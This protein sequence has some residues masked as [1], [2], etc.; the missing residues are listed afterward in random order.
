MFF[1]DKK[2]VN[3]L[4][5]VIGIVLLC[6]LEGIIIINKNRNAEPVEELVF[7]HSSGFYEENFELTLS[8]DKGE[9]YYTLDGS[10]PDRNSFFYEGPISISDATMNENVYSMR[11]DVSTGFLKEQIE[12]YSPD[13]EFIGYIQPDYLVDKAI[14]VR[15]VVYYDM[16]RHSEVETASYF[17]GFSQKNGYEGMNVLS[18]VTDP[19]NL[20]GYEKGIYVTGETFD[21][22]WEDRPEDGETGWMDDGW[23]WWPANYRNKGSEW[24]REAVCQF[25]DENGNL[26]LNQSCGIRIQG[27]I[28]RGQNPRGLN[29]YARKEYDGEG[30]FQYS[31]FDKDFLPSSLTLSPG[32][33]D[34]Y[35]KLKDPLFSQLVEGTNVAT[36]D[37]KPYVLFLDGEYWGVYWLSER[38]DETYFEYHYGVDKQNVVIIKNGELEA[39]SS[40]DL[41]IYENMVNT[42]SSLDMT[43]D[44]NYDK[45][46][47]LIDMDSYMDYYAVMIYAARWGDWP[48]SNYALWR[49]KLVDESKAYEDGKWRW[50]VFDMNSSG[51]T[52]D[53]VSFDSIQYVMENDKMFNNLMTNDA[54]RTEFLNR[55]KEYGNTLFDAQ[56]ANQL[57][58]EHVTLMME[59]LLQN[60][61][62]FFGE[63]SEEKIYSKIYPVKTFFDYRSMYMNE[64]IGAYE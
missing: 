58:D 55:I 33:N 64:I 59:P 36:L 2:K 37:Y 63:E 8:S 1:C 5:I 20:F 49:T 57:I 29:L 10:T 44:E 23:R 9:I 26:L 61:K 7:S 28:T 43:I 39:G 18:I 47:D 56:K 13:Q 42:C 54:F 3:Y 22:Y 46:C 35:A 6:I 41:R 11:T 32:G 62:R 60:Q 52:E 38:Y 31:F 4:M 24:E 16:F 51:L 53:F 30:K 17:V 21:K 25:F 14:V 15:A 40:E 34:V 45:A 27:G 48:S 12:A 50:M 19:D